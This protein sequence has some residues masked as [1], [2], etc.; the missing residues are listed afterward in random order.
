M[1]TQPLEEAATRVERRH[2]PRKKFRGSIEIEWGS[3]VL[4]G[5]V[6]DIGPRGL[7][8]ELIPPLWLGAAFRARLIVSPVL[9]IDCTVVRVEPG[10]GVAVTFEV[11]EGG[12]RAQ[13]E[14][15]LV[16]LPAT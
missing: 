5:I 15:L 11:A 9:L 8:V 2:F 6:R 16:S 10:I 7:F 1:S 3:A 4:N 12:G 13:M 14:K